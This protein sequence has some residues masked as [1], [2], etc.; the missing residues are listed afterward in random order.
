MKKIK[1]YDVP[2]WAK[3]YMNSE[4][5][6]QIFECLWIDWRYLRWKDKDWDIGI[7]QL[8]EYWI[9]EPYQWMVYEILDLI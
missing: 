7:W 2:K 3:C 8:K 5:W 4:K 6:E 9:D 1:W